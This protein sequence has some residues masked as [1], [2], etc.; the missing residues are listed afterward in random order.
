MREDARA[1]ARM[2]RPRGPVGAA[3]DGQIVAEAE[4][5]GRVVT[6]LLGEGE[7]A[8]ADAASDIRLVVEGC[9]LQ[10][11]SACAGLP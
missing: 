5:G 9:R 2:G 4:L 3:A 6:V 11:R 8:H 1:V 7:G 10:Q